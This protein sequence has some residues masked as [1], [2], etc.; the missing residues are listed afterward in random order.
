M[1]PDTEDMSMLMCKEPPSW[2]VQE[3]EDAVEEVDLAA[4]VDPEIR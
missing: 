2:L 3:R 1:P 4:D